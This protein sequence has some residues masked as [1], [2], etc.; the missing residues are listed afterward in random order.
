[1]KNRII[2]IMSAVIF[3]T[4]LFMGNGPAAGLEVK[5]DLS[6][7]YRLDDLDWNIAGNIGGTS[8]NILSEL[9][10]RDLEIYQLKAGVRAVVHDVIVLRTSLGFGTIVDGDNQDSD[11]AGDNRTLEFSRSNNSGDAGDVLDWTVGLGY[12]FKL[13]SGRLRFVPLIG[14]SYSEQ[15][16]TM[17]DGFQT[18]STPG[19]T[20]SLG[21]F[22]N[23]HSTYETEWSG[24]W[25][26]ADL[27]YR[28]SDGLDLFLGIEYH[29][30]DYY[31]EANWN[32]RT[33]WAH[34]KSFEHAADGTGFVFSAGGEYL[35]EGG[36]SLT[37]EFN[38]QDWSTDAGI[39]RTFFAG[40]F[41][42][43]TRLNEANWES[44][45]AMLGVTYRFELKFPR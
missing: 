3:S 22:G 16:L 31:A 33:D 26:G 43:D 32:L 34:P 25:I 17:T 12:R 44:L 39:D 19:R 15:N 30:A 28:V 37:L 14:Y 10:W 23:L 2:I 40:G 11:F 45:A 7:G 42:F 6:G 21:P 18:I 29:R 41:V 9:T 20:P 36:W 5:L 24:P 38:Y 35:L 1:M 13:F 4:V 27:S 8:P